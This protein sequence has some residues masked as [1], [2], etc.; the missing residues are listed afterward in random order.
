M[1]V[2]TLSEGCLI[3]ALLL[4][5]IKIFHLVRLA[6]KLYDCPNK[7]KGYLVIVKAATQYS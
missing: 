4:D 6:F 7:K 2:T 3:Y 5:R 1:A